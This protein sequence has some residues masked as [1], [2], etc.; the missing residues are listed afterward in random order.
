MA[1]R[2]KLGLE[3][4]ILEEASDLKDK[5]VGLITH[6]AAVT[7][8]LTDSAS[9]LK[10]AGV[11]LCALFSPEHGINSLEADGKSIENSFDQRLHLPIYSLY[12]ESREPTPAM[13]ADIDILMIDLQDVGVRFYTYISTLFYG[14]RAAGKTGIEV[15]VLDRPNPLGGVKVEG[16]RINPE[17]LSF[18]GIT[19]LPIRHGLTIGEMALYMNSELHLD[20]RLSVIKMNGWRRTMDYLETGHPWVPTSPAMPHV[21]TIFCYPGTCLAEGTNLSEGRGTPLPFEYVGAPWLDEYEL[22]GH[23]N[24][25]GLGGVRFRPT[26]FIPLNDKHAGRV[27]HGV[28]VHVLNQDIFLPVR[29]GLEIIQACRMLVPQDFIFL[30]SSW[31]EPLP[32]FDL[33]IGDIQLREGIQAGIPVRDLIQGWQG[34]EE[35]FL[36]QRKPFLLYD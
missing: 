4:F 7:G 32:H 1:A 9:A 34:Q 6:P 15:I 28:Q 21:S 31:E 30:P 3:V 12:G 24:S 5:R 19:P 13:L 26:I 25:L 20:A 29:S 2:I 8:D 35:D 10:I 33:L 16:P 22:A 27:C 11:N 17:L 23:L 36:L 14:L 18:V